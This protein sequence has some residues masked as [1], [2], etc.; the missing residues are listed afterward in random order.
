MACANPGVM[1]G[2]TPY[3]GL[4]SLAIE[5]TM[6]IEPIR[7]IL[8]GLLALGVLTLPFYI[9]LAVVS[10]AAL[11]ARRSGPRPR[12]MGPRF[13]IA[14]PAH[15]EQAVIGSTVRSCLGV[16]YPPGM[17]EVLVVADNCQ[18]ETAECARQ[19]GA[20]VLERF[21]HTERS[22]G[23]ALRFLFDQLISSGQLDRFDAVVI[24]DADTTV[25]RDLLWGFADQ[26][27]RGSDWVQAFDT[28]AN[29]HDSWRTRLMT[30]SFTLINGVL[31]LGQT[32]LGLSAALRG[33]GMCLSSRGLRRRPWQSFG[34][35][36]DLEFSWLLRTAGE[37]IAFASEVAVHATMLAE[38]G[39]AAVHQRLRWERG[40][41]QLKR[42]MLG[43]LLTS[44]ALGPIEKTAAVI[45]LL[46]PP[47]VV[48]TTVTVA[49]IACTLTLVASNRHWASDPE[50][51]ALGV[52]NILAAS[53]LAIHGLS[54]FLAFGLDWSLLLSLTRLPAY[55]FWRLVNVRRPRP[56][57]WVRTARFI[58]PGN[59]QTDRTWQNSPETRI[60]PDDLHRA[61][62]PRD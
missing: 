60:G 43:A 6:A 15:D 17:F 36:E 2:P 4:R 23:H 55:A 49:S 54:A 35:V 1:L 56:Q 21:Q 52:L 27:E 61:I 12:E 19:E 38:G 26:L 31:L 51:R 16:N 20:T 18:D 29:R 24:V 28:V 47:L 30:L 7:V 62:V 53:C 25:D 37:K 46:M 45:E 22:K 8:W 57:T 3:V 11:R 32:T 39:I 50:L 41:S 34:L 13:L 42:K 48:L 14:I 10:L 9:Y 33:N 5:I 44:P 59:A 58:P 40:R